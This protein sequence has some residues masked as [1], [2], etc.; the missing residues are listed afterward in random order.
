MQSGDEK[1]DSSKNNITELL[2]AW[3]EG[4][5]AARDEL[6]PLVYNRL[7]GM[8][9]NLLRR[10]RPDHSLATAGLVNEAYLR[11]IDQSRVQWRDRSHFFAIASQMMRRILVD[12]ARS[13]AR[14]KR[15]GKAQHVPLDELAWVSPEKPPSLLALDEALNALA[16]YDPKAAQLVELRYFG[17][18]N[19]YELAEALGISTATVARRWRVV[20]AWLHSYLVRGERHEL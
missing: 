13:Q 1:E 19:K 8:A 16:S 14:E 6:I 2:I 4:N 5:V 12:H 10:E 15:G 17:G 11:L 18:L 20:R 7:R 9:K 3:R